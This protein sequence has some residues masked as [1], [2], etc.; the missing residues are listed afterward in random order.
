MLNKHLTRPYTHSV[1]INDQENFLFLFIEDM[2]MNIGKRKYIQYIGAV[3][4]TNPKMLF[5]AANP[6]IGIYIEKRKK[7][8]ERKRSTGKRKIVLQMPY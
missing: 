4:K 6:C 8:N 7:K 1:A 3:N 2:F 5:I